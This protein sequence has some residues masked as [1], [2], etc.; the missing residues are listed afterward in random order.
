MSLGN[1]FGDGDE[2]VAGTV[3]HG[4]ELRVGP[5]GSQPDHCEAVLVYVLETM[6]ERL[7]T[8]QSGHL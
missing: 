7:E 6:F 1:R 2:F 8:Y 5:S 3:H 4:I